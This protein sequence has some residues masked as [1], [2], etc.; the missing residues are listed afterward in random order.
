MSVNFMYFGKVPQLNGASIFFKSFIDNK[1]FLEREIG[2][3]I[4]FFYLTAISSKRDSPS[5]KYKIRFRNFIISIMKKTSLGSYLLYYLL[6]IRNANKVL[7]KFT[8]KEKNKDVFIFND[9][10]IANQFIKRYPHELKLF[11][12]LH[13]DGNPFKMLFNE[14]PLLNNFSKIKKISIMLSLQVQRLSFFQ[15][16]LLT[17]SATFI[18]KKRQ[19][20]KYK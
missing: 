17:Y 11:L 8:L 2:S 7:K 19:C 10:F 12:I 14:F 20:Y 18:L 6:Y 16:K 5:P 9:F 1:F 13:N 15:R 4:S 3:N